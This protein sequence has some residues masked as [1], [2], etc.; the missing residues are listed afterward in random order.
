MLEGLVS[1]KK[2]GRPLLGLEVEKDL[3][4][5]RSLEELGSDEKFVRTWLGREVWKNLA[6]TRSLGKEVPK[7]NFGD[8]PFSARLHLIN[9]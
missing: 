7:K 5:T 3:A 2:L 6:R 8:W 9:L 4:W 1:D